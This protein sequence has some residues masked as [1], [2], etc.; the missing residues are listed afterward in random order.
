MFQTLIKRLEL[1]CLECIAGVNR[2]DLNW[3]QA[4][5]SAPGKKERKNGKF[6]WKI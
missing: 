5:F 4:V 6:Q 1:F 2:A 3:N